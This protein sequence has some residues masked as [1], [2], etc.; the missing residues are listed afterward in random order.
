[1]SQ[2]EAIFKPASGTGNCR[3][4]EWLLG[5][6]EIIKHFYNLYAATI[7][8]AKLFVKKDKNNLLWIPTKKQ[9]QYVST[10]QHFKSKSSKFS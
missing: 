3:L 1:V 5:V 9:S 8:N 6:L 10:L 2:L 7:F 4:Q